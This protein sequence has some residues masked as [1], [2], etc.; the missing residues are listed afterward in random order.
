[1]A[2]IDVALSKE[3]VDPRASTEVAVVID[4]LMATTT[5]A[6]AL[7]HGVPRVLPVTGAEAARAAARGA[8]EGALLAGEWLGVKIPGFASM[9]PRRWPWPEAR[10]RSLIVTS[11]NGTVA[12][13]R[14]WAAREL[15]AAA[16]INATAVAGHVASRQ[17]GADVLL[18]CAGSEGK[19]ALDDAIAAGCL[20]DRLAG[21]GWRMGAN[22]QRVLEL[23]RTHSG[24]LAGAL[25]SSHAGRWMAFAGWGELIALAAAADRFPVVPRREDGWLVAAGPEAPPGSSATAG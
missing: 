19:F 24:A 14:A 11:T 20:T 16:L 9:D 17:A 5:I 23:Y 2:R 21:L 13:R 3:D 18:V 7:A 6:Y 22:A 4:V 15:Y 8:G 10:E 25:R 1:M 12:L